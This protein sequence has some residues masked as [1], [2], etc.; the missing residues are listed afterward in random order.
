[1]AE[2]AAGALSLGLTF[3]TATQQ[4]TSISS[5]I[6]NALGRIASGIARGLG[7][8]TAFAAR[9]LM[10]VLRELA[11]RIIDFTFNLLREYFR[12][13]VEKPEIGVTATLLLLYLLA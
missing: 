7:F 4:A 1:M 10:R 2:A 8:L 13:L 9:E 11:R 5:S 3:A 6:A 12:L